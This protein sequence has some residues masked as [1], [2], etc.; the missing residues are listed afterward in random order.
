MPLWGYENDNDPT[1]MA[2][3][4]DAAADNGVDHFLF[5]CALLPNHPHLPPPRTHTRLYHTVDTLQP[6]SLS[7]PTFRVILLLARV[8]Q[9]I[10]TTRRE[11]SFK[12]MR[13]RKG[14]L[15]L[16]IARRWT[17]RS[18]GAHCP[19]VLNQHG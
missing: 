2:K 1:V 5:D 4:I 9:G 19:C 6:H 3:K 10:G 12:T 14:F 11:D 17:L 15:Q 8:L 16:P 18:C 13:S 7:H